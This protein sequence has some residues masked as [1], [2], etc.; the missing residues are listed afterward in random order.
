MPNGN[1]KIVK[2]TLKD[3]GFVETGSSKSWTLWWHIGPLR[4]EDYLALKSHQKVNHH[5][6]THECTKK[7]KMNQN[8][9]SMACKFGKAFDFVPKT[10]LLPQELS[11]LIRDN[12][13]KK[14]QRR[15]YIVKPNA[16]SQGR[17]IYVTDDLQLVAAG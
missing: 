14:H 5:P 2:N 1:I 7:D 17:G 3:N 8:L 9:A 16:A 11:L 12:D 4:S 6:L 15:F 13:A 10:Y